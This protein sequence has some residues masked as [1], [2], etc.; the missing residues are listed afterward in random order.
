MALVTADEFVYG[1][2]SRVCV[3][4]VTTFTVPA[5]A[6]HL[7]HIRQEMKKSKLE[8]TNS[9]LFSIVL[10]ICA[11]QFCGVGIRAAFFTI[12]NKSEC[13]V[14]I[15]FALIVYIEIKFSMYMTLSFRLGMSN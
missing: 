1:W 14:L 15:P 8:W 12:S 7:Y 6:N 11:V 2:I 13:T 3:V 4:F 9:L 5:L 10:L